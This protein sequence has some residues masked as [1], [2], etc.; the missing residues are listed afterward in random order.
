[1]NPNLS[2]LHPYPFQKLRELFLGVV[3]NPDLKPVNLS[4]GE[5]KHATPTLVTE[6]LTANLGGLA[7]Y[8][9][10][11]GSEALRQAAAQEEARRQEADESPPDEVPADARQARADDQYIDVGGAVV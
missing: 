6:A 8:P 10:T 1:M 7:Q 3:P 11:Q 5:P 2:L 4:I 9:A